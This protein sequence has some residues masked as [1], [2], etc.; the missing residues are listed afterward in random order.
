L[1]QHASLGGVRQHAKTN[2]RAK[3]QAAQP[4]VRECA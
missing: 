3:P 1:R 2:H 4:Q